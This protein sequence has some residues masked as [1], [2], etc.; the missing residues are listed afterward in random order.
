MIEV[1]LFSV[2]ILVVG[3]VLL[4]V[5]GSFLLAAAPANEEQSAPAPARTRE[6]PRPLWGLP[7]TMT[8]ARAAMRRNRRD[9]TS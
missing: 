1:V 2:A 3:L 7:Q 4:L 8:A 9:A 5:A 6:L